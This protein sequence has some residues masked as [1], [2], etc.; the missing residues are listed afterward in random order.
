MWIFTQNEDN[1]HGVQ[2]Y[3]RNADNIH[4]TWIFPKNADNIHRTWIFP[5]NADI[6]TIISTTRMKWFNL[7]HNFI[8][9]PYLL[10]YFWKIVIRNPPKIM[11][12]YLPTNYMNYQNRCPHF[13]VKL[14]LTCGHLNF[15]LNNPPISLIIWETNNVVTLHKIFCAIVWFRYP[16]IYI[17]YGILFKNIR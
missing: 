16:S 14:F 17:I 9:H 1:I 15:T 11:Q 10:Q 7:T 8:A 3:P 13:L 4:L 6:S 5:W 12:P 2:T